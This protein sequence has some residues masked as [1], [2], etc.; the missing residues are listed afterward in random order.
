MYSPPLRRS[1]ISRDSAEEVHQGTAGLLLLEGQPPERSLRSTT[2]REDLQHGEEPVLQKLFT[3]RF[4]QYLG[5]L[6]YSLY[7]L[8]DVVNHGIGMRYL[9][10]AWSEWEAAEAEATRLGASSAM[11]AETLRENFL[12]HYFWL[13]VKAMIVNT[14]VLF[15]VSDVFTRAVDVHAI[16]L[17]RRIQGW[18]WAKP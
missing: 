16:K 8:H 13:W 1:S 7:L 4:A 11:L 3:N 9:H 10:P 15:W 17:A 5:E 6:S 2:S 18:V 12:Q 14:F